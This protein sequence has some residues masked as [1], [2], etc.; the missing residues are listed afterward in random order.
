MVIHLKN[1]N[2]FTVSFTYIFCR[3]MQKHRHWV[4]FVFFLLSIGKKQIF[5]TNRPTHWYSAMGVK[6]VLQL[7]YK[8]WSFL[9][10]C[11]R[12]QIRSVSLSFLQCK[13]E[14]YSVGPRLLLTLLRASVVSIRQSASWLI[15]ATPQSLDQL[16]SINLTLIEWSFV[17][18]ITRFKVLQYEGCYN[19]VGNT[20]PDGEIWN[21]T[22]V[23]SVASQTMWVNFFLYSYFVHSR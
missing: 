12:R 11:F 2:S 7:M 5:E 18:K 8:L 22:I 13:P 9:C 6:N 3:I 4:N 23:T 10:Y 15:R 20:A 1:W 19:F 17:W 14:D 21:G 16:P